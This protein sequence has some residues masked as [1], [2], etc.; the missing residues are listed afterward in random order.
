MWRSPQPC[1]HAPRGPVA[2]WSP[3]TF[4]KGGHRFKYL[5]T[6]FSHVDPDDG[7]LLNLLTV[8]RIRIHEDE[9]WITKRKKNKTFSSDVCSLWRTGS[10]YC[11]FNV[12]VEA[13]EYIYCFY[14]IIV[15]FYVIKSLDLDPDPDSQ[16][17]TWIRIRI[18]WIWISNTTYSLSAKKM[19]K[20]A[21]MHYFF[22][23]FY[24]VQHF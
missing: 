10:F 3:R 24:D 11:S 9:K 16:Q 15:Q 6:S 22:L 20:N 19:R 8:F 5:K 1:P 4:C 12:L 2:C 21:A 17:K 14:F 13:W 23:D 18:Q 7:F